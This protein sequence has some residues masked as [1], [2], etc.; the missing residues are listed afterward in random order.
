MSVKRTHELLYLDPMQSVVVEIELIAAAEARK[1]LP[2]RGDP[3]GLDL[4]GELRRRAAQTAASSS[5]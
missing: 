4:V 1:Q 2:P 3:P 5:L